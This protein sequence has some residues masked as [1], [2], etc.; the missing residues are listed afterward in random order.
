M[1]KTLTELS[2]FLSFQAFAGAQEP[3]SI[4]VEPYVTE[5]SAPRNSISLSYGYGGVVDMLV[6][7]SVGLVDSFLNFISNIFDGHDQ[8]PDITGS[9]ATMYGNVSLDYARR[10]NGWLW[11]GGI[12][13]VDGITFTRYLSNGVTSSR[14]ALYWSAMASVKADWLRRERGTFYSK[15]SAGIWG[16]VAD[17]EQLI[18]PAVNV[19]LVGREFGSENFRGFLEAGIGT[20]YML[21]AGIRYR[22]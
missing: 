5:D 7:S 3:E 12:A 10:V 14:N 11:L 20:Q 9:K 4:V 1:K 17:P 2:L 19:T 6:S 18:A 16:V 21:S 8:I 13:G 22:F 15:I